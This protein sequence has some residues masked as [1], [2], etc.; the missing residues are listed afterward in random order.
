M[1][2]ISNYWSLK[3][4]KKVCCMRI[5]ITPDLPPSFRAQATK[6]GDYGEYLYRPQNEKKL[7]QQLGYIPTQSKLAVLIGR[8]GNKDEYIESLE[9]RQRYVPDIEIITYD[10]ILETHAA[11]MSRIVIPDFDESPIRLGRLSRRAF[12]L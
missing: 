11:Q 3:G 2:R 10:K 12:R 9:R 8:A 4:L 7:L 5:S 6:S 1:P